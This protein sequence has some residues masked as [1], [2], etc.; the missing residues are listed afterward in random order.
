MVSA[1]EGEIKMEIEEAKAK[2]K[3]ACVC[4]ITNWE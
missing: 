4:D 1:E 2:F 3:M